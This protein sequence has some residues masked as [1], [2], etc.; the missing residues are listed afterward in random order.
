MIRINKLITYSGRKMPLV[1]SN[2]ES[3]WLQLYS[4]EIDGKIVGFDRSAKQQYFGNDHMI[5]KDALQLT[6]EDGIVLIGGAF[7]WVA[8]DWIATGLSV[9][10]TDTSTWIQAHKAEQATIPILFESS[11]TPESRATIAEA[12]GRPITVVITED[13]LPNLTDN[14]CVELS[15][16]MRLMS[17]NVVHW[18]SCAT[19][20]SGGGLNWKTADEWKQLLGPDRIVRRGTSEVI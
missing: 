1:D 15:N 4:C 6:P 19:P 13:V 12:M 9:I 16:A 18:V 10:V 17:Q 3:T 20:S 2:L 8:E 14:E 5:L 7:G 11:L